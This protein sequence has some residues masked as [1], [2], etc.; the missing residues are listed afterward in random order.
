MTG[1]R[2][3]PVVGTR[4]LT[5]YQV[6]YNFFTKNY[7]VLGRCN[8]CDRP[9]FSKNRKFA[10]KG[11]CLCCTAA[12]EDGLRDRLV[13]AFNPKLKNWSLIDTVAGGIIARSSGEAPF[14][15]VKKAELPGRR[16]T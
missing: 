2:F 15:D 12:Y 13:Q 4:R 10:K 9:I 5:I 7:R 14:T 8:I 3:K 11:L 16:S 1:D 6:F